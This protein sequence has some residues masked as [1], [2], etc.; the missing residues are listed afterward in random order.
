MDIALYSCEGSENAKSAGEGANAALERER[1]NINQSLLALAKPTLPAGGT[2]SVTLR[3]CARDLLD[4]GLGIDR[5][6]LPNKLHV[7]V[8][9][10]ATREAEALVELDAP[11]VCES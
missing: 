1:K 6:P 11:L 9:D 8:G 5:Q 3:V 7:W 2:A 10:A 4:A